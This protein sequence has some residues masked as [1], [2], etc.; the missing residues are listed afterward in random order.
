MKNSA[1]ILNVASRVNLILLMTFLI[2]FVLL[3][4]VASL[5]NVFIL[6]GATLIVAYLL[7]GPVSWVESFLI[8][9]TGLGR[10]IKRQLDR[11]AALL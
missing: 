11:T 3:Y 2:L 6:L 4:I 9:R 8:H 5:T 1:G 10:R 7:L